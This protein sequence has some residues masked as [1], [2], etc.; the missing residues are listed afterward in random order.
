MSKIPR[1][2]RKDLLKKEINEHTKDSG[3]RALYKALLNQPYVLLVELM[4]EK[5]KLI[6]VMSNTRLSQ[7]ARD[8]AFWKCIGHIQHCA[9]TAQAHMRTAFMCEETEPLEQQLKK[10]KTKSRP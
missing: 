9:G 1:C 6:K 5:D 4:R 2:K 3:R 7:E 8:R 10:K